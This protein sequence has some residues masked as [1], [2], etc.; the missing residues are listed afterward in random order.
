M[1]LEEE[2]ARTKPKE[3]HALKEA[4]AESEQNSAFKHSTDNN[5][6]WAQTG[7]DTVTAGNRKMANY[8]WYKAIIDPPIGHR[9]AF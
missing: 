4:G 5:K 9:C 8:D 6:S 2:M 1:Q 3:A 7:H